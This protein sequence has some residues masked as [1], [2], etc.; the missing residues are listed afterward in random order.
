MKAYVP[1]LEGKGRDG[2]VMSFRVR[3]V[4]TTE[5]LLVS[6]QSVATGALVGTVQYTRFTVEDV[7]EPSMVR[8]SRTANR[9]EREPL[10]SLLVRSRR[11][12][13]IK[14]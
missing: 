6:G 13:K 8:S 5:T 10:V 12:P 11:E 3:L 2:S 14:P 4:A 9:V 1:V 7:V